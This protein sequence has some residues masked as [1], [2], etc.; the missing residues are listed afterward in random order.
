[1]LRHRIIGRRVVLSS[2]QE[3]GILLLSEL[4]KALALILELGLAE[5]CIRMEL[6]EVRVA[7]VHV[8]VGPSS[9]K[10]PHW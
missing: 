9:T 1:M 5:E 2:S 6:S 3:W 4:L 8:T 10:S 7:R